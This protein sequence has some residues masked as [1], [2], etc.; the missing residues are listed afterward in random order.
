MINLDGV[1][2]VLGDI[3]R[4][5]QE[6][7]GLFA[8]KYD[9]AYLR[10]RRL[11][12]FKPRDFAAHFRNQSEPKVIAEIK[13]AS[14][15][16][17]EIAPGQ[18]PVK[19]AG[20]YLANGAHAL[21]VLTEPEFFRGDINFLRKIRE[22]HPEAF[23]LMKDFIVDPLQLEQ[24]MWAG[25]DCILLIVALLP[26]DGLADLYRAACGMGLSVLVEVH[27]EAELNLALELAPQMIG[28]NNRNL[29]DMSISLEVTA[30]LAAQVPPETVIIGESGI[31]T[32]QDM[33][34]LARLGCAGFLVGTHLMA[35]PDPGLAL[36]RLLQPVEV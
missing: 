19:V 27:D 35:Q 7:I 18:H 25:A 15:T 26:P 29:K 14:P 31:K 32:N 4:R 30:S 1:A 3:G 20:Q 24:A 12:G 10:E 23:L 9:A 28:I 34:Y 8:Q 21:S 6:R 17:G 22:R 36:A 16:Q 13:R 11:P 33:R 5:S 2:G